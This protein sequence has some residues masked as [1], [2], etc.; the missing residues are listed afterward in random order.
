MNWCPKLRL[1]TKVVKL[2][3]FIYH[4]RNIIVDNKKLRK[5]I[6]YMKEEVYEWNNS[7]W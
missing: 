1:Q 5:L 2:N 7:W 3:D 4:D 6:K